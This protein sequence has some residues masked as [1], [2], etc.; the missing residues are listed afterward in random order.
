[1]KKFILPVLALGAGVMSAQGVITE[2]EKPLGLTVR[3]GAI[4]PTTRNLDQPI[5]TTSKLGNIGFA[6]GVEWEFMK[7]FD[8]KKEDAT[9]GVSVS[10]DAYGGNRFSNIPILVN[11]TG[12]VDQF[13]YSV[14]AGYGFGRVKYDAPVG[15]QTRNR[16]AYQASVGYEFSKGQTPMF[17]EARWYGSS[18]RHLNGIAAMVGV[19]F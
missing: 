9:A 3:V 12:R 1:M 10:V 8:E 17:V 6:G 11:Y 7:L 18:E 5:G 15:S 14:G 16:F 2:G 13:L 19:R 4:F